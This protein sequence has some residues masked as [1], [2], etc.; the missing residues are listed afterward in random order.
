MTAQVS[1]GFYSSDIQQCLL[2]RYSVQIRP[3]R[4]NLGMQHV[5]AAILLS[6]ALQR[7]IAMHSSTEHSR[8]G[9]STIPESK[10]TGQMTFGSPLVAKINGY[11]K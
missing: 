10:S 5:H 6:R 2:F 3:I 11:K 1:T 7:S 4:D 9:N 8:H